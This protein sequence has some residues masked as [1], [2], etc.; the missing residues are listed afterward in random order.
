MDILLE[1]NVAYLLLVAGFFLAL[2][3]VLS[4]GTG[5]LELGAVF[6]L[7]LA[8]Y[9]VYNTPINF[10]ALGILIL[11]V[12]PF[13]LAVR[14]SRQTA[15]LVIAIAALVVGSV[16]L[17]RS[18]EGGAAVNPVLALLV[19]TLV[20][21]Y[22]WIATRK[23]LEADQ[24]RPT[25]DLGALIG[26]TGEA[27]SAILDEGS[28]QVAGELWSATSAQPVATGERVRVVGREGFVLRVEKLKESQ[29]SPSSV[30]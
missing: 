26:L 24:A 13:F 2:M 17:F 11:G 21:G 22:F 27:K 23:F 7:L 29:E 19:S 15:Y 5:F 18:P 28:V 12:I 14:K 6:A 20:A 25:H 4:P 8:G 10:W 1:P 3:A 16:F 9:A 30:P